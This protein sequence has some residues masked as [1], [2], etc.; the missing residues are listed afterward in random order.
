[1]IPPVKQRI[2]TIKDRR[3]PL[4]ALAGDSKIHP[5]GGTACRRPTVGEEHYLRKSYP[6]IPGPRPDCCLASLSTALTE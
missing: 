3:D 2:T 4:L 5:A 1:M 6:A